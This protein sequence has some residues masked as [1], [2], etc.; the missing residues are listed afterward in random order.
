MMTMNVFA[1]AIIKEKKA[2][3][4]LTSRN[5]GERNMVKCCKGHFVDESSIVLLRGTPS[6]ICKEHADMLKISHW[7][8]GEYVSHQKNFTMIDGRLVYT[9]ARS[10]LND[11][12]RS[13]GGRAHIKTLW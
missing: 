13:S 8:D 1:N 4:Y 2:F 11:P 9:G 7:L 10:V 12:M 6:A 5:Q 3:A